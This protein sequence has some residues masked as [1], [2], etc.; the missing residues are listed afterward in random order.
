M[1]L[2]VYLCIGLALW[3]I[4]VP[5]R[6][7]FSWYGNERRGVALVVVLLLVV[8]IALNL[9]VPEQWRAVVERLD[10]PE[11]RVGGEGRRDRARA[12][13][14]ALDK[15]DA[16]RG[17]GLISRP[18]PQREEDRRREEAAAARARERYEAEQQ[19]LGQ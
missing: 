2:V 10:R 18:T 12:P 19:R 14:K 4:L 11:V 17:R 3:A 13:K 15:S 9:D 7:L 8:S 1:E 6:L 16:P 5:F